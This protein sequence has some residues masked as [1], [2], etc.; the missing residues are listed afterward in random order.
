MA[1][2]YGNPVPQYLDDNGNPLAGGKL[3]FYESDTT[4]PQAVYSDAALTVP[5]TSVTLDAAG[6]CPNIFASYEDTYRVVLKNSSEVTIWT[7]DNVQFADVQQLVTLAAELQAQ[8]DSIET[9]VTNAN[10]IKNPTTE[11]ITADDSVT[12]TTSFQPHVCVGID[13]RVAANVTAGTMQSG[14]LSGLGSTSRQA[15]MAGVSGDSS[16]I[17]EW[18]FRVASAEARRFANETCS[19]SAAI[20]QESGLTATTTIAVYKANAADDFSATTLVGSTSTNVASSTN[21]TIQYAGL[22]MGDVSNG[23]ELVIRCQ[24]GAAF[25]TKDF[26][27]T[28]IKIEIGATAADFSPPSY[29]EAR[30]EALGV[31]LGVFR[32][33]G[34]ANAAVVTTRE[35]VSLYDGLTLVVY[36][37]TG[38]SAS[39]TLN[40][41]G[42]GNTAVVR[43]DNTAC[44]DGDTGTGYYRFRYS[45]ALSKWVLENPEIRKRT[46]SAD[47]LV[48]TT[49][50]AS[51]TITNGYGVSSV[52]RNA[53]GNYTVTMADTY[54][55]SG[56]YPTLRPHVIPYHAGVNS[57]SPKIGATTTTTF[58]VHFENDSGTRED[59]DTG[60]FVTATGDYA[61]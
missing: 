33:T 46:L 1:G 15:K 61:S 57:R 38:N 42:N 26:Y 20:R 8:I 43:S 18:R 44:R 11:V 12:L 30:A 34:T 7:K 3:Y 41:D 59:P 58:T 39:M 40:V 37:P 6:R 22:A 60:F 24:P 21:A 14:T 50:P 55:S 56:G 35:A 17:V 28:D 27:L 47:C 54:T 51:P 9:I 45:G 4:T 19:I 52:V 32:D 36:R 10:P 13:G 49:V 25:V 53:A 48:N 31:G 2:R 23:I 5:A 29:Q 16:S